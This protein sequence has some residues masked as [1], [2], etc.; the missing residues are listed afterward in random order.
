MRTHCLN[1]SLLATSDNM[2]YS[3]YNQ[4]RHA[5]IEVISYNKLLADAKKRNDIFFNK[6]FE[7]KLEKIKHISE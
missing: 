3:G 6:L 4:G 2:G 1:S 5:Y 7:P